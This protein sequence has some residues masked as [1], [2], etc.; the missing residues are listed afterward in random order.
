MS[1]TFVGNQSHLVYVPAIAPGGTEICFDL[2]AC[3]RSQTCSFCS[4]PLTLQHPVPPADAFAP[5]LR[6][7]LNMSE[8]LI[9]TRWSDIPA[10][11]LNSLL[12]R[13]FVTGSQSMFA[14]IELKKGCIVPRHQHPNEQISYITQGALRFLLG[15]EGNAI[16]KIVREGEIL[17]IP[18]NVPHS[19]EALEDSVDFDIFAPPR[20]DWITGDDA[21][22]R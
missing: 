21:Y 9:H 2:R 13:Q 16:E 18:G 10:T 20:K 3:W 4:V 1:I 15:D 19:A 6:Y 11:Q 5:R 12:T 8:E 7:S 22:L 14:R 17:V